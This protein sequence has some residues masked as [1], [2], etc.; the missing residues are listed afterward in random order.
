MRSHVE[1]MLYKTLRR[2]GN[3]HKLSWESYFKLLKKYPLVKAKIKVNIYEIIR[4]L[5]VDAL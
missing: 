1:V 3:R 2:R 4:G 5:K